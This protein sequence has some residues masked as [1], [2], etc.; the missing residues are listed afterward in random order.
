MAEIPPVPQM[1]GYPPLRR[2]I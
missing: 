1:F 2:G